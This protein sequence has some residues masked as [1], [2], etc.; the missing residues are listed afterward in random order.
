[1]EDTTRSRGAE[2]CMPLLRNR[3]KHPAPSKQGQLDPVNVDRPN[4]KWIAR[5]AAASSSQQQP[6]AQNHTNQ[7]NDTE[8]VRNR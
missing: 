1:M 2:G 8:Y 5:A 7:A 6:A 3:L 4:L